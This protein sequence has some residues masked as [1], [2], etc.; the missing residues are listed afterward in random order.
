MR[1]AD[2][3]RFVGDEV[4]LK[5]NKA[6]AGRSTYLEGTL[7]ATSRDEG[8]HDLV[9]LRLAGGEELAIGRDEITGARLVFRWN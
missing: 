5:G 8:G 7:V 9:R 4:A 3:S 2:W 6:L 1:E